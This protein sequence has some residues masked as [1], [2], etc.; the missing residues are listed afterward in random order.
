[1]K[2]LLKL[3]DFIFASFLTASLVFIISAFAV[4]LIFIYKNFTSDP[5][6]LTKISNEITWRIDGNWADTPGN[7]WYE[8]K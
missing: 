4:Q 2:T 3:K 6:E 5:E 8:E 7:I 1:M